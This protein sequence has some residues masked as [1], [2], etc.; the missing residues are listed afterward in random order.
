MHI[1]SRRIAVSFRYWLIPVG[2]KVHA[3][4]F[5]TALAI[6]L[7]GMAAAPVGIWLA[8]EG[9]FLPISTFVVLAQLTVSLIALKMNKTWWW[10]LRTAVLVFTL[11]WGIEFLGSTTG[12]PFG[13]YSYTPALQPQLFGVPFLIP[14]AWLMMLGPAWGISEAI[15]GPKGSKWAHAVLT[16]LAFSAWDLYLDPQMVDKGLWVWHEP[17]GYFG[18]PWVNFAGWWLGAS[19]LTLLIRPN[20]L[21][22]RPLFLV[23]ALTWAFQAVGL[24]IFWG[25][26]GPA[27]A[28]FVGMGIFVILSG[29]KVLL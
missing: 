1:S 2:S 5:A 23:Y 14:L 6:W 26:P 4:I 3:K 8:G 16:G 17:G 18:I 11:T 19:L 25:Q 7:V 13:E 21:A 29:R 28:G 9:T 27:L 12:F 24:G 20:K 10:T 15:L 22:T